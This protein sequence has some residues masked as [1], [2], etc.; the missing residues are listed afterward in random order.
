MA[1]FSHSASRVLVEMEDG[2]IVVVPCWTILTFL[3][4]HHEAKL[5]QW[6]LE[7]QHNNKKGKKQKAEFKKL[8]NQFTSAKYKSNL[9]F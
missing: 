5:T 6:Q 3:A 8:T 2:T 4:S 1:K 9:C 7:I